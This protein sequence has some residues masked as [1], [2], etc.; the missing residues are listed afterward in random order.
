M[1]QLIHLQLTNAVLSANTAT[2]AHD[3][4]MNDSIDGSGFLNKIIITRA[5][6]FGKIEMQVTITHMTETD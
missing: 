2:Q 4:I 6:G 5:I 1:R 3:Y